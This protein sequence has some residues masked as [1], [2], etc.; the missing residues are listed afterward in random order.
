MV[1]RAILI[2]INYLDTPSLLLR[3]CINDILAMRTMLVDA[4]SY[5]EENIIMMRDD[6]APGS[7]MPTRQNIMREITEMLKTSLSTDE[8][9][10][11]F[12]GHGGSIKDYSGDEKDGMDEVLVPSDYA[13]GGG[14]I[15]DDEL[16]LIADK[17]KC[18]VYLTMDCCHS[19]TNWDLPFS[20]YL[21]GNRIFRHLENRR[22][23]TNPR[24]YKLSGSR[25][26]QYAMDSY[27]HEE[28]IPMGAFTMGLIQCLRRANHSIGLIRLFLNINNY[29]IE[30]RYTQRCILSSSSPLPF[31][32]ITRS[33]MRNVGTLELITRELEEFQVEDGIITEDM[34][35]TD[36]LTG[37]NKEEEDKDE[38]EDENE[39]EETV[40]T[41]QEVIYK[42]Y[43]VYIKVEVE[44]PVIVYKDRPT[45]N[46]LV[47]NNMNTILSW[48]KK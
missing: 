20:F 26:D 16:R 12:S 31:V 41:T 19:G 36:I 48:N 22:L 30:R 8:V 17:A 3:G 38:N 40:N 43:P 24:V 29:L 13:R 9:W 10:I 28:Q 35:V 18:L 11:H 27:N 1:K 4:Y 39:N 25:D 2:G 15:I 44:K 23:M 7:V 37:D 42:P 34:D 14:L 21:Q 46:S 5:R 32:N 47:L 6:K 33:R 45:K